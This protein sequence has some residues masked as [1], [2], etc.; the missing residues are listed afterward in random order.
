M[1]NN[2]NNQ[3]IIV[4]VG[5]DP[6][7]IPNALETINLHPDAVTVNVSMASPYAAPP[8]TEIAF[9]NDFDPGFLMLSFQANI[10]PNDFIINK[11][12]GYSAVSIPGIEPYQQYNN[13]DFIEL[14]DDFRNRLIQTGKNYPMF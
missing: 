5:A 8:P 4:Q 13:G 11:S 14:S 7:A 12:A 9:V 6:A 10:N 1:L 3:N 2:S